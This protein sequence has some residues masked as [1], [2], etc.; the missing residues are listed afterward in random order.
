MSALAPWQLRV[1]D[2]A[3]AAL[4]A[5]RLGHGLLL[6]GPPRLGKREVAERL[7]ARVLCEDTASGMAPCGQ[8]RSCRLI[9]ARSQLDPPEVRPDGSPAHP[10]GHPAHPDLLLVGHAWNHKARPPRMRTE[11]VIDQV[12]AL[13]EQMALT[14]QYGRA[15]VAIIDPGE[16]VNTAAANALLKTLEEPVPGRYLWIVASEPARLPATIRSRCQK[17]EFRLPPRAEAREWLLG[18]GHAE[19]DVDEAL[20][21]TRGHPGQAHAWMREGVLELRREVAR[22]LADAGAGRAAVPELAQAWTADA[23]GPLRLQ[24]AADLA[25]AQASANLTDPARTRS[26]AEWFD[27]ANKARDLLQSTVRA[28]LVVVELLLA[29]RAVHARP[30]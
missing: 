4:D 13:G 12:R 27:R 30:G 3:A 16:A 15:K 24:L 5:G 11:I 22:G 19:A 8:C 28:D 6:C 20:E 2:R 9:A 21:A 1:H 25:L 14:P 17:L 10:L 26:L 29:W 7:A 23:N 18:Q